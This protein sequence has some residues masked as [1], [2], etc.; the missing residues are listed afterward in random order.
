MAAAGRAG[1]SQRSVARRYGVSLFTVQAWAR[2]AQG[3]RLD[4]V[5][6]TDHPSGPSSSPRRTDDAIED[7]ILQV[8]RELKETS[9]LGEFGA[10]LV[11]FILYLALGWIQIQ[12]VA[13]LDR[14]SILLGVL[15]LAG[16][17]L[18]FLLQSAGEEIIF[19]GYY[20][21]NLMQCWRPEVAIT[22]TAV[23][24]SLLHCANPGFSPLG[25][26]NIFF[27]GVWFALAYLLTRSLWLPIGFHWGWN[28]SLSV[29]FG[30]P[31]SGVNFPAVFRVKMSETGALWTGGA[32]GPEGGIAVTLL[33]SALLLGTVWM[34]HQ[35][36]SGSLVADHAFSDSSQRYD[37]PSNVI[38]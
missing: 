9:D 32:F 14:P 31:V 19:R 7:L 17:V 8:R 22:V 29:V 33:T 23:S 37:S 16:F 34:L 4:R 10:A 21:Q 1:E 13:W 24:F 18:C 26:F 3:R 2:R 11:L 6:W 12:S 20:F 30:F 5:D 36:G 38:Q 28:A 35:S 27:I 25:A 15:S